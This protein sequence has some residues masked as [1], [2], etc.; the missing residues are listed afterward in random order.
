[1][2]IN[3][4]IRAREVRVVTDA[5]EQLGIMTT[6]DALKL[7]LEKQ[8]DLVEI[9]PNSKPPVCK[10]MDYG[11]FKYEQQ[12]RDK[13]TRKK[14]KTFTLKEVKLR[15]AI[16]EHDFDVKFRAALRF[17]EEGDKV[18]FTIMF[19]GRELARPDQGAELLKEMA[20]K[21]ADI[22][23]ME[24]EAKLEGKNMI[25]ILAPKVNK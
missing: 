3:D 13:E 6:K 10:I 23:T 24:R 17:L 8:M 22:A 5:G 1:M 4:E 21:L 7:A 12:K 19:R 9:V 15:P 14:Q 2:R 20:A 18:K 25:M 11:R 16:D